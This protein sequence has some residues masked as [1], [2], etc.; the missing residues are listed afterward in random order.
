MAY[1]PI[2]F[3][4]SRRQPHRHRQLLQ[5]PRR[6]PSPG[7]TQI[8][9]CLRLLPRTGRPAPKQRRAP[10]HRLPHEAAAIWSCP[11]SACRPTVSARTLAAHPQQPAARVQ[12]EQRQRPRLA[13]GNERTG[14]RQSG[15]DRLVHVPHRRAGRGQ[16]YKLCGPSWST[17]EPE[18]AGGTALVGWNIS[19][20]APCTPTQ[21]AV[22][23]HEYS[24]NNSDIMNGN[25]FLVGR[26]RQLFAACESRHRRPGLL[27]TEWGWNADTTQRSHRHAAHPPG[28]ALYRQH[29]RSREPPPYLGRAS[30]ALPTS[31]KLIAPCKPTPSAASGKAA[32]GSLTHCRGPR[33]RH[34]RVYQLIHSSVSDAQAETI[35][36][37]APPAAA[38]HL[39]ER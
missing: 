15:M 3:H 5:R 1:C 10:R 32:A 11:I 28:A 14:Q 20:C 8:C 22:A 18:P 21:V 26:F 2:G 24:L 13:G 7:R 39:L 38:H 34:D 19:G 12:P 31:P 35:F 37:A 23:T 4:R 36:R 30:A 16:G 33:T 27:I 17:G 9:R 6:R 29:P 25:G